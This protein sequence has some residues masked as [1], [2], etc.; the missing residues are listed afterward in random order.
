MSLISVI[1]PVFNVQNYVVDA[2]E[3]ILNQNCDFEL[4]IVNDGSTD[5]SAKI[6]EQFVG[7]SRVHIV[8]IKNSGLSIARNTGLAIAKGQYVF[9][10]DSD[11]V[12]RKNFFKKITPILIEDNPDGIMFDFEQCDDKSVDQLSETKVQSIKRK[13]NLNKLETLHGVMDEN[14]PVMAWS[15]IVKRE[16]MIKNNILYTPNVLFEDSNSAP[17]IFSAGNMFIRIVFN[18]PPYLYRQ[19]SGS[20]MSD[21]RKKKSLKMLNDA[22]IVAEDTN[23]VYEN[24][25]KSRAARWYFNKLNLLHLDYYDDLKND[26]K[27]QVILKDLKKKSRT[28]FL[29]TKS[30]L[31]AYEILRFLRVQNKGI[32]KCI[33]FMKG[34][35]ND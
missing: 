12:L 21:V 17:K 26:V 31:S 30:C 9:F 13:I 19:R 23:R 18:T 28:A 29:S 4:I 24:Y 1:M 33:R 32:D 3:S 8:T 10:M 25:V 22:V 27:A 11:D 14:I 7:D 15:Y 16:M 35:Y 6:I 20:I 5:G 34:E 2:V